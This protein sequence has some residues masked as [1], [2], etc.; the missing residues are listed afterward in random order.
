MLTKYFTTSKL[1]VLL[2]ELREFKTALTNLTVIVELTVHLGFEPTNSNSRS[3]QVCLLR[4]R[5]LKF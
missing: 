1:K 2:L 5:R 4:Y 3:K